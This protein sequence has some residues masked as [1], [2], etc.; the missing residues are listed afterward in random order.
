[1]AYRALGNTWGVLQPLQLIMIRMKGLSPYW[2]SLPWTQGSA[3]LAGNLC[4]QSS[5]V[6]LPKGSASAPPTQTPP[7]GHWME[8]ERT[9]E[10]SSALSAYINPGCTRGEITFL[11]Y[12]Q[13]DLDFW[14]INFFKSS[15]RAN[16]ATFS[17]S[18]FSLNLLYFLI[19][20]QMIRNMKI[21]VN[22][23]FNQ[24]AISSHV[25]MKDNLCNFGDLEASLSENV[26]SSH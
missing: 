21:L 1:M 23:I 9:K 4:E 5:C 10:T 25:K 7:Q 2:L 11:L 15:E 19:T 14:N 12:D 13:R 24:N 18:C 17:F 20:F 22:N 26:F 3:F 6:L 8:M 16:L